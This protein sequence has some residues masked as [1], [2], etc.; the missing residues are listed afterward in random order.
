MLESEYLEFHMNNVSVIEYVKACA[1]EQS[2]SLITSQ[3]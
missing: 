2:F 1:D 3:L